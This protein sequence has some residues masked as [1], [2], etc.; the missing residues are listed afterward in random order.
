V[1]ADIEVNLKIPSL[2]IRAP[3]KSDVR[4][5][6]GPI[7]F[8]KRITVEAI[9]KAGDWLSVSTRDGGPFECSVTRADWSDEKNLFVVSCT[10]GRRSITA[11]EH[12]ALLADP[13]WATK[14]LP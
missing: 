2:T 5:D 8:T 4:V 6:N 10:Y 12:D 11:A 3:G 13:D 1:A 7:R 9:P 14:Q